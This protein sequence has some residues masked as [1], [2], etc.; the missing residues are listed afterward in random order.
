MNMILI[1]HCVLSC[2]WI[3]FVWF[4]G[5]IFCSLKKN[6]FVRFIFGFLGHFVIKMFTFTQTMNNNKQFPKI[7][8]L[9][10]LP[11]AAVATATAAAPSSF[12]DEYINYFYHLVSDFGFDFWF[13]SFSDSF[14]QICT[15]INHHCI[16][17]LTTRSFQSNIN[18]NNITH[19]REAKN[20][21]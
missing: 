16:F 21:S 5:L 18:P 2:K 15:R 6:G 14:L 8:I 20:L 7:A 10:S 1:L 4:F 19:R 17:S 13:V 12:A 3:L 11:A 9:I